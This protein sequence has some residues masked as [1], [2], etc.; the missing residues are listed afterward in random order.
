MG[1]AADVERSVVDYFNGKPGSRLSG[2]AIFVHKVWKKAVKEEVWLK[3][4]AFADKA[5]KDNFIAKFAPLGGIDLSL[6]E[7]QKQFEL[8]RVQFDKVYRR[9]DV[10]A[11]S[12]EQAAE[13]KALND[14]ENLFNRTEPD[15]YVYDGSKTIAWIGDPT[16]KTTGGGMA[17]VD[18]DK[19]AVPEFWA[20][21][22]SEPQEGKSIVT[23]IQQ[24]K[25]TLSGFEKEGLLNITMKFPPPFGQMKL[26]LDPRK[27]NCLVE[28][29]VEMGEAFL[30][31]T[32]CTDYVRTDS[33]RWFPMVYRLEKY[34]QIDNRLVLT[35]I[36][37]YRA[38]PGTVDFD[39]PLKEDSFKIKLKPG[40]LVL[41]RRVT[42]PSEVIIPADK[43]SFEDGAQRSTAP[44]Q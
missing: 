3:G 7:D 11:I 28:H 6:K 16:K 19:I 41:D 4:L 33:G 38:I 20:F 22:V 43:D 13:S 12:E 24:G 10:L 14:V 25:L 31:K 32:V 42:P 39:L 26:I 40:T 18:R 17:F 15:S 29:S 30:S 8:C 37:E 44:N 34:A 9:K 2:T 36:D 5:A 1:T 27:E 23:M 35:V 21:G